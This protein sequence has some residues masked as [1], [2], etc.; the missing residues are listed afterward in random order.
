ML[1]DPNYWED[2][3]VIL[4]DHK[5]TLWFGTRTGLFKHRDGKS[6]HYGIREGLPNEEIHA[7]IE[8]RQGD[9]W[10]G[11][12]GGLVHYQN[13][14]FTSYTEAEGLSSNRVRSLHPDRAFAIW[15]GTYDGGLNRLKDGRLTRYTM[16]DGLFSNGVFQIL[17]DDAGNFWMSSNQGIYR[18]SRRQLNDFADR[19]LARLTSIS[20]EVIDGMLN[21]EC[22]G[23]RQPAGIRSRDGRLWFPTL[24]GVVSI[25]PKGVSF[26]RLPPPVLIDSVLLNRKDTSLGDGVE[27]P[28]GQQNL[29]IQY[30]ALSFIRPELLSFRYKIEGLDEDWIEAGNRRSAFYSYIPAGEYIFRVIAA[31][32]DGVWNQEG[33]TI[34]I[35][36]I[37][38]FYQTWWFQSLIIISFLGIVGLIYRLRIE[39]LKRAQAAQQAFSRRLVSTQEME[40]KR[41]ASELHDGLGQNLLVIK[42]R[43]LIGA[44][45]SDPDSKATEQFKEI[46]SIVSEAITE[47]KQI[48]YNLRPLH[49]DRFGLKSA[50]EDYDRKGRCLIRHS[51][52]F[53]YSSARRI[54]LQRVRNQPLS[55]H[56][57]EH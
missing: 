29:E 27:I 5:G 28:A 35:V 50:L 47:A 23:G 34:K 44:S 33:A 39:S 54:V 20:Y 51:I 26:N 6:R 13:G 41:I 22:N 45:L 53:A 46:D 49:L 38:P 19:R 43:A 25:D 16:D 3:N 24:R 42:N 9:L 1:G 10:I 52:L 11:T 31:N 55:N 18:V 8:D 12:Y 4:R 7:M 30:T 48:A 56:S 17:E 36:V 40:R 14:Q 57:G 32:A 21:S 15:I 37:P 2:I